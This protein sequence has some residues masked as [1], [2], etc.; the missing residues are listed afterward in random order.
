M[1]QL[2]LG[3]IRLFNVRY[4]SYK[5]WY[6]TCWY[7]WLD[8]CTDYYRQV[9]WWIITVIQSKNCGTRIAIWKSHFNF[10]H[11]LHNYTKY[12]LYSDLTLNLKQWKQISAMRQL[13]HY[14]LVLLI[15]SL[16]Q[17]FAVESK[18]KPCASLN[19]WAGANWGA[20]VD[21]LHPLSTI[22]KQ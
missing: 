14:N 11:K 19:R 4:S 13:V 3:S 18:E 17:L 22:Q 6:M 10:S 21:Q 16:H 1:E 15:G 2:N 20:P 12:E 7:L 9:C 5:W 8:E